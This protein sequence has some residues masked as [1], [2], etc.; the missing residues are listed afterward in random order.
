MKARPALA[1]ALACAVPACLVLLAGCGAKSPDYQSLWTTS[2]TATTTA[3]PEPLTTIGQ[4]LQ[5]RSVTAEPVAPGSLPDL[6]VSIPTPPGWS[7]R[8]GPKLP[9]TTEVIGKGDRFPRALL[10]A[11][12]LAGGEFDP[13]IAIQHGM[14]DA[15]LAKNFT[16]LDSS[17]AD[18]HGFPSVMV[19]GSH[20]LD[21]QRVQS[22]FR[23]VIA[24]GAPPTKLQYLVQLTIITLAS[25]AKAQ[26]ADIETI[27]KGFTV[28]PK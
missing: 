12:R 4:Y 24:T 15:G 1:A 6:T 23:M 10:T 9:A 5:A 26:A 2:A 22:W 16:Q 20:D 27:I 25:Q 11:M 7:K 19:Q 8:T 3:T 13:A 17:I 21:G 28:A 18:Y 14:V